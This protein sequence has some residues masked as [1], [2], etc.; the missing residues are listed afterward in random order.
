MEGASEVARHLLFRDVLRGDDDVRRRYTELKT[1]LRDLY[2]DD[3]NTYAQAK[4]PFVD[5][6][7]KAAGWTD[8]RAADRK[9]PNPNADD[10]TRFSQ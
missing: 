2:G 9:P 3:S 10:W 6:I 8:G 4:D 1:Q 5:Q 7:L